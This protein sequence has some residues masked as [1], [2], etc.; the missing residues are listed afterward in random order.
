MRRL[1]R[2]VGLVLIL[3]LGAGVAGLLW[4]RG[5]L[6]VLDGTV[7]VA[8]AAAPIEIHRDANG[9]PHIAAESEADAYFGL[10]FVHAQDR[11]WQME[12]MRRSGAGRLSELLG[13]RALDTDRYLRTMGFYRAAQQSLDHFSVRSLALIEAY[14]AGVNAFLASHDGPL[15]PEFVLFRHRPEPWTPADS[16]V[17]V[18]MMAPLLAGNARD[19]LLRRKLLEFLRPDQVADMWPPYPGTASPTE[20]FSGPLVPLPAGLIEAG[21]A[22]LPGGP[23][24]S[25]GSNNWV[26]DGR[27][28]RSGKPILAND[29]HLGLTV[30]APWYLAHLRAPGFGV[31]G[32]TLPGIPTVVVG[33]NGRVAWGVTNTGADVQ[34]LFV[35]RIDPDDRDRYLTPDGSQPFAR[36]EEVIAVTGGPAEVLIVRETRHGPVVSEVSARYAMADEGHVLAMA[37]VAQAGDDTTLQAGLGLARAESWQDMV[38]ALRD[39]HTPQQ[40]FVGADVDGMI[41]FIAPGRVPIRRAGDGWLPAAGWTG[42]GD[43][44]GFIPFDELPRLLAPA[45]GRI[46]T[47]NQ[48]IVADEYPHFIARDWATPYRARRIEEL[49]DGGDRHGVVGF[50]AIQTD[51]VSTMAR[52]FLPILLASAPAGHAEDPIRARLAAWDGSMHRY[53]AEPLIFH[54]WYRAL[55]QRI[56]GDELG[57][58]FRAAWRRRPNFIYRTL[59]ENPAW[60]DDVD[61]PRAESCAVQIEAALDSARGWLEDSYGDDIDGWRWAEAHPAHS[62]HRPFSAIPVIGPL[63]DLKIGHGGGPYTVMQANTTIADEAAPFAEVHGAALRV[64]FDLGDDDSGQVMI[65]TGQSGNRLSPHYDDLARRWADGVY[66]AMPMTGAAIERI[67]VHRLRLE[68]AE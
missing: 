50:K 47:A 58:A 24:I 32:A 19:E 23:P 16:V 61:T 41:G 35:E 22:A 45:E 30:P 54:A 1:L 36:R 25:V 56:Y 39:F 15:P 51:V 21:L 67:T 40:N 17:A 13:D 3:G 37:W 8:G 52:D 60:C 33:R 48:K 10:G 14:C 11:L 34:D 57:A 27:R 7:A 53:M 38:A 2:L 68:P 62:R 9:I 5:S 12:L 20:S 18:K 44:I 29:P 63:F 42:D 64:I 31:A 66:V 59:T 46:V 49:L 28:T 26:V 55:T 43:W 4:L 6:P 65:H